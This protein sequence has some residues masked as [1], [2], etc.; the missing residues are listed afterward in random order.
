M[1]KRFFIANWKMQKTFN[2]SIAFAQKH[3]HGLTQLA[4]HENNQ[5]VL[6]PS[7]PALYSM[8]NMLNET[9]IAIG[10]Q[11]V[12][13]HP[14]GAYTG[15]VCAQSLKEAGC[16]YCIIGHSESR[17]YQKE[18][19]VDIEHKCKELIKQHIT[20][21][22]CI[23]ESKL[24]FESGQTYQ[25]LSEQLQPILETIATANHDIPCY[26]IAYEPIWAIGS[27]VIPEKAY[28][29]DVFAWLHQQCSNNSDTPFHLLYG[30]SVNHEN[31]SAILSINYINGLLIGGASLTFDSFNAIINQK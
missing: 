26:L 21:I 22:I 6:C 9:N 7:F 10:A 4:T 1:K 19:T 14:S 29:K 16:T 11:N 20:P 31:A 23:G 17:K 27:G 8:R 2:E 25:V 12:S 13:R 3:A 30:G 5:I 15:Q 24:A 28:I 18:T